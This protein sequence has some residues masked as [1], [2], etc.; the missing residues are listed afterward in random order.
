MAIKLVTPKEPKTPKRKSKPYYILTIDYMIGD[1]NGAT[2]ETAEISADNP[3]LE[4]FC[5]I[6]NKLKS[7]KGRWG[8]MLNYETIEA[9]YKQKHITR[10]EANFMICMMNENHE[11]YDEG[12]K[13]YLK[14]EEEK[15]FAYE[16]TGIC[17]ADTEYS[18][19][20]YEGFELIY[21]DE[22]KKHHQTKIK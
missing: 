13:D 15:N 7:P 12:L 5:K 17:R 21:V 3:F 16:F 9:N 6:L 14:T 20:T 4:R 18:F 11:D 22:Y 2:S 19:L 1:A 10:D 8:I